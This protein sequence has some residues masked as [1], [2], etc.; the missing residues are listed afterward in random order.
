MKEQDLS[1]DIA[2][3]RAAQAAVTTSRER[4]MPLLSLAVAS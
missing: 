4:W 1:A 2:A 3:I